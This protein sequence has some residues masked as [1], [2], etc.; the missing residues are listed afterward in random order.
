MTLN[1][2]NSEDYISAQAF[3]LFHACLRHDGTYEEAARALIACQWLSDRLALLRTYF[4]VRHCC[5]FGPVFKFFRDHQ[6]APSQEVLKMEG[7]DYDFEFEEMINDYKA[8]VSDLPLMKTNAEMD[9]AFKKTVNVIQ[10]QAI[11]SAGE[12]SG[13]IVLSEKKPTKLISPTTGKEE[14]Y[15]GLDGARRYLAEVLASP[16]QEDPFA[17]PSRIHKPGDWRDD[18]SDA[19]DELLEPPSERI[20]TGIRAIDDAV[21]IRK[22]ELVGILGHT[23]SGKSRLGRSICYN[24]AILQNRNVLHIVTEG[25]GRR[26]ERVRYAVCHAHH[27]DPKR[28]RELGITFSAYS[29]GV[30]PEKAMSFLKEAI[31][32]LHRKDGGITVVSPKDRSWQGVTEIIQS[33]LGKR[34]AD[35]LY[36]DY[37]THLQPVTSRDPRAEISKIIH[38]AQNLAA[39]YDRGRGVAFVTPVQGNRKGYE[40]AAN[41]GGVWSTE[42]L[43]EYSA[44]GMDCDLLLYVFQDEDLKQSGQIKVGTAKARSSA[45]M[46]CNTLGVASMTQMIQDRDYPTGIPVSLDDIMDVV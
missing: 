19:I 8:L 22:G 34:P 12:R 14:E 46:V 41:L 1:Y 35:L 26:V 44:F 37:L 3:T 33:E 7:M 21:A 30:L 15:T 32:D 5:L 16:L 23:G 36:V 38:G 27:L 28:A 6:A 2:K 31:E 24:A 10:R 39:T 43:F 25:G 45:G 13:L 11:V 42:G 18:L 4:P 29:N 40:A 9:F 17:I 20:F